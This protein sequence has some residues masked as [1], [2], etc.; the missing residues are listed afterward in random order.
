MKK[1]SLADSFGPS[2]M[3]AWITNR[4][5]L[6]SRFSEQCPQMPEFA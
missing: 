5:A 6:I 2:W 1:P 4:F 3:T